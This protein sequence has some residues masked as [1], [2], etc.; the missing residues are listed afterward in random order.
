LLALRDIKSTFATQERFQTH[1]KYLKFYQH[2]NLSAHI[3]DYSTVESVEK[4]H[5]S[6]SYK[7]LGELDIYNEPAIKRYLERYDD[8][9]CSKYIWFNNSEGLMNLG[10]YSGPDASYGK[11]YKLK[12]IGD[13][14]Y[15]YLVYRCIS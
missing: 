4:I 7:S 6:K 2:S 15:I 5:L 11:R 10:C 13:D 8:P 3:V 9:N 12:L 14:L 1:L